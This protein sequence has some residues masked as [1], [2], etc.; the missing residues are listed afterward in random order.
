MGTKQYRVNSEKGKIEF[1]TPKGISS[2]PII[3]EQQKNVMLGKLEDAGY[4]AEVAV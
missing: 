1:M 4:V 3:D 2:L